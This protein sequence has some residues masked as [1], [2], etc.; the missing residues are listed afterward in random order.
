MP[1]NKKKKKNIMREGMILHR[2]DWMDE[3]VKRSS[4]QS[5]EIRC[6]LAKPI[7]VITAENT[8]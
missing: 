3:S 7:D 8:P 5:K 2:E 1:S 6:A 4:T